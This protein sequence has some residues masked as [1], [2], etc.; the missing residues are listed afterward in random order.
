MADKSFSIEFPRLPETVAKMARLTGLGSRQMAASAFS[1]AEEVMTR[2]KE[3]CPVDT[4]TLRSTGHV[5]PPENNG[6]GFEIVLGFGG[7]AAEYA[8]IVHENLD[9][10]HTEGQQ[11][12]YLET[13]L[14]E[15]LPQITRAMEEAFQ[16]EFD[17]VFS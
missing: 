9:A 5:V 11:A 14:N 4:G 1:Q 7:P 10:R 16:A 3:L 2:A 6:N 13:P 15:A 17:K 8:L 12:K